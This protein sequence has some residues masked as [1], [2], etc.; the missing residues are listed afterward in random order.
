MPLKVSE[1]VSVYFRNLAQ[2][3][4]DISPHLERA[5]FTFGNNKIP[6]GLKGNFHIDQ[7]K[8]MVNY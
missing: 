2:P 7:A 4:P 1:T 6:C 3:L 8:N 5:I